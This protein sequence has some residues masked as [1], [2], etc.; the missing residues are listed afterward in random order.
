MALKIRGGLTVLVASFV[1]LAASAD[2]TLLLQEDF[3]SGVLPVGWSHYSSGPAEGDEGNADCS[4]IHFLD[5][6]IDGTSMVLGTDTDYPGGC[7][8]ATGA[9]TGPLDLSEC[10]VVGFYGKFMD[11]GDE[12][13]FCPVS[14]NAEEPPAADCLGF[15]LDGETV[16]LET[17][18]TDHDEHVV[19][20]QM[21]QLPNDIPVL[22]VYF[23]MSQY[24]NM[25]P[26][27]SDGDGY[28]DDGMALDDLYVICDPYEADCLD[29]EDDDLDGVVDCDDEDCLDRDADGDGVLVCEGD[30][31]DDR[32][33][34][35]PGAEEI[36]DGLDNDC[37][38]Q[39]LAGEEDGDGDGFLS[40][41]DDCDD[42]DAAIHP[43]AV[44]VCDDGV[45]NDCDGV[46][47]D[48]DPQ[49]SVAGDDDD[50]AASGDGTGGDC[51]CGV[52]PV[53]SE[54][55]FPVALALAAVGL[56]RLRGR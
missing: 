1:C 35:H 6:G 3:E 8:Q 26:I 56:R 37:D 42:G 5:V 17:S 12:S 54:S 40:C 24:D 49:C 11:L 52:G 36:C 47:D 30:C 14:W 28:I 9:M 29:G 23:Y 32:A 44:E 41:S 39:L 15:S 34:T 2:Q 19:E 10:S 45:D 46:A 53:R 43:Q 51:S 13:H 25:P 48:A 50:S 18:L 21:R 4:E 55:V 33:E 7:Y 31:D 22:E 27:D 20:V 16:I 38:E